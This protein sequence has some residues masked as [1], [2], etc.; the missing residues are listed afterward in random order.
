MG[1]NNCYAASVLGH[2]CWVIC[3]VPLQ[4][5]AKIEGGNERGHGAM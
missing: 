2:L 4:H 1:R 3:A 5:L